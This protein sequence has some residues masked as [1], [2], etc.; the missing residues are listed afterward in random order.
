MSDNNYPVGNTFSQR[1]LTKP[2]N[3]KIP[4][5]MQGSGLNLDE[6]CTTIEQSAVP[7]TM[8]AHKSSIPEATATKIIQGRKL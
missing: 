5:S 1:D 2:Y 8:D 6:G 7:A 4:R 3:Q